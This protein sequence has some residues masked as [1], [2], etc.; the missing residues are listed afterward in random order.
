MLFEL[1]YPFF[2]LI[3]ERDVYPVEYGD[4]LIT[5]YVFAVFKRIGRRVIVAAGEFAPG[6]ARWFYINYIGFCFLIPLKK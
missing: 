2:F 3:V 5:I 6:V 1:C 4:A